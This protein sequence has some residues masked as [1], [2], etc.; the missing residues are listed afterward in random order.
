[1]GCEFRD[2]RAQHRHEP[3]AE[4]RRG[5]IAKAVLGGR[6]VPAEIQLR[7]LAEDRPVHLLEASARIDAEVVHQHAPRLVVDLESLRLPARAVER[8]HQLTT[9]TFAEWMLV[10]QQLELAD[11]TGVPSGLELSV[12]AFLQ[13]GKTKLFEAP[14]LGLRKLLEGEIGERRSAP[15]RQRLAQL[16]CSLV[17]SQ[18][19]GRGD[20]HPEALEIELLGLDAEQ[21]TRRPR[22]QDVV[23]QDLPQV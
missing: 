22:H 12:D 16:R 20:E 17:G 9:K 14:D 1:M 5:E 15:E 10:D 7:V 6:R 8:E 11:E 13:R 19:F 18:S 4:H 23:S 3:P 21:V 2:L